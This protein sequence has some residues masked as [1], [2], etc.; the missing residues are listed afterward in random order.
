MATVWANGIDIFYHITGNGPPL[1]LIMGMGCSARQWRWM[2]PMLSTAFQ[3]ITF[4]NRGA[5]RTGKPAMEYTT[6][7]FAED[8]CALLN[9]L[10]IEK[11]HVF[12]VSVGGMIA[13]KVAIQFPEMVDRLVLGCTMPNFYHL[14]PEE[15]DSQRL[16]ESQVLPLEQGLDV[17]MGLF[18]TEH[19]CREHPDQAV[20]LKEIMRIEREEQGREAL[21]LQL[22]AAMNHD[23]LEQVQNIS[24]PALVIT[25]DVDPM[26]P[27][28]NA[29]FLAEKIPNGTL[30][31]IPG[32][33][34]ALWVERCEETA[35]IIIKFLGQ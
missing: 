8:T 25:G 10:G 6:D 33:R 14:P 4:D 24:A 23:T 22:A 35:E 21:L 30:A 20:R 12:G 26:A 31:E 15:E 1:T 34:H 9:T 29:R 7:L 28:Q 17:M 19:F 27:V 3:V 11:T 16:Q 2:L 5:G 13:Q 32:V 18:L